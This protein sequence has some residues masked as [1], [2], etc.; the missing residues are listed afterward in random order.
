MLKSFLNAYQDFWIKA[1]DFKSSTTRLEWWVVQLAN[2]I[3]SFLT[4]PIFL[5]TFGFNVY[6]ILC[7][8]PQLAID[9]RRLRDFG[10]DWKWI[11]IN[12]VPIFGWILWFLWLGFGATGHG[13]EISLEINQLTNNTFDSS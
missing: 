12:L 7:I 9:I 4:I 11:F 5:R 1:T 8:L 3:I 6:G 10:K 13:K 2:I